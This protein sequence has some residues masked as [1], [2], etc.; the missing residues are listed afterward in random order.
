M[1]TRIVHHVM[2]RLIA[3]EIGRRDA[4]VVV[5]QEVFVGSDVDHLIAIAAEG[6]L[7][8]SQYMH[9]GFLGG[10]LLILSRWSILYTRSFP[11]RCPYVIRRKGGP[12]GHV[13]RLASSSWL[14]SLSSNNQ[15]SR[16]AYRITGGLC[17]PERVI[18]RPLTA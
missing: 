12:E 4:D 8:H 3:E 7:K 15:K 17:T 10:E 6:S 1:S 11:L 14:T 2:H 16:Q 13:P 9:S 18:L 5:L